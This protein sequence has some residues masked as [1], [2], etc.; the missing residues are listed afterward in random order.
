MHHYVK[1]LFL[2]DYVCNNWPLPYSFGLGLE[3]CD[4][5]LALASETKTESDWALASDV[6]DLVT[7]LLGIHKQY[8]YCNAF[9]YPMIKVLGQDH[10]RHH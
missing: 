8:S 9:H 6:V 10:L 2:R 1:L 3:C 4:S 7:S 5:A